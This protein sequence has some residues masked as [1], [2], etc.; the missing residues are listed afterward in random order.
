LDEHIDS[1]AMKY[2]GQEK[3]PFRQEG[4]TRLIVKIEPEHVSGMGTED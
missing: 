3:Y 4:E 2:L 1:L